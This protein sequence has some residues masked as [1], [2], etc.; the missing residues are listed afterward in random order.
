MRLLRRVQV[1]GVSSLP[2]IGRIGGRGGGGRRRLLRHRGRRGGGG[3]RSG[4]GGCSARGRRGGGFALLRALR[5]LDEAAVVL[6]DVLIGAVEA[7][8]LAV[9]LRGA[10]EVA[11]R[12]EGHGQVVAG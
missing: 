1:R 9:L 2:S 10:V 12:F 6:L 8:R 5:E 7:E 11:V 3:R 4:Y